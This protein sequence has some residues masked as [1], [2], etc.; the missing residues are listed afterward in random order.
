MRLTHRQRAFVNAYL[1]N[2]GNGTK[3]AVSAGYAEGSASVAGSRLLSDPRIQHALAN[4]VDKAQMTAD[5]AIE[6]VGTIAKHQV[7]KVSASDKLK[8]LELILKAKGAL[9]DKDT[10]KGITVN[11]GFIQQKDNQPAAVI[12]EV[13]DGTQVMA[14]Q[15][16]VLP[17]T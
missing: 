10:P 4:G 1:G 11:I 5:E 16:L 7:S 8:A 6:E 12:A 2:G 14:T 15:A 17:G 3:A 9:R 13:S